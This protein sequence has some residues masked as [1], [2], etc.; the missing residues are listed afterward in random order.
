VAGRGGGTRGGSAGKSGDGGEAGPGSGE[1]LKEYR[2]KRDFGKTREPA[3]AE[4]EASR[5]GRLRFIIQKHRASHLHYDLRLEMGGVL[6]S[7][8]VPKGPSR[9]PTVRRL[10]MAVEDHPIEYGDFEGTIPAGEYGGGT[11][12]LWDRGTYRRGVE[13]GEEERALLGDLER[14]KLSLIF[15]GERLRGGYTLVRSGSRDGGDRQWLLIKQR[16]AEAEE[17]SELTEEV[18]TSVATGRRMEEIAV[19]AGGA[20][21]WRSNRKG[22][23]RG[24]AVRRAAVPDVASF[25]PMLA[26][27]GGGMPSGDEWTFELKYDGIRVLAVARGRSVGLI[28]RNGNDK[29][30]QFPE[31]VEALRALVAAVGRPLILDGE[32]VALRQGGVARF[33]ALQGRM[34]LTRRA[35]IEAQREAAPAAFVAFDLLLEGRTVH[36]PLAWV[37]RREALEGVFEGLPAEAAGTVRLAE[38]SRDGSGMRRQ[39]EREGW[40]GLVAKRVEAPYALGKR[41]PAWRKIK[42]ENRQEL[43]VGGYT[44]PRKS[45]KHIGSLLLGYYD[46]AG[47]LIYAGHTGT[48]FNRE[49]LE[50]LGRRLRRLER[51]TPPFRERPRTNET[52]HWVTPKLVVEVKFN[53]WTADGKLRQPSF[54][55]LRDDKDPRAV[56]REPV[57]G[58][59]AVE[60]AAAAPSSPVAAALAEI[61]AGGGDGVVRPGRGAR[62]SVTNLGKVFFPGPGYTK[63]D[64]LRYYADMAELILPA[65]KDRPLVLKR[66]PN[67]IGGQSFYQQTPAEDVPKGVRVETVSGEEGE[68]QRRLVGGELAT[69]LYTVQLGAISYDPWHSRVGR[70]NYPDYAIVDLDPGPD[71][72]FQRVVEVARRVREAMDELGLSG[73]LKTSGAS[74]LHISLPLPARTPAEAA[75]LVAQIVA[76]RVAQRHPAIA[77]VERMTRNR[78]AGTVYVDY[79]QNI[80]G[81]TIAGVYAVRAREGA[82][83][84]TPLRWEELKDGLDPM[85]FTIRTVPE[86][87]ARTGDLWAAGM[88]RKNTLKE[89]LASKR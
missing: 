62:L 40:E 61:E 59:A 10:A 22:G 65:M 51:K 86:R 16:D 69:L 1:R 80:V 13:E 9:D 67:G 34:H 83:V 72:P 30:R 84:S 37:A 20:R 50:S 21:V 45:R 2:R 47:D 29:A 54:V 4:R 70:L 26:S 57:L 79:L 41:S 17:G 6:K 56:V 15:E 89:L 5:E 53:E 66:Y 31:I 77:T 8:A 7:W 81:K 60:V 32:I 48:G 14:G 71:V 35:E 78:P 88:K 87:V 49:T 42:L 82:T 64:V 38:T 25:R 68:V 58:E 46:A 12:M 3:G 44:E 24:Q 55:G 76:T 85:A 18:D 63:G 27:A 43:V 52:A 11:V 33:G 23:G 74:G 39:A 19:G 28:T 36:V 73:A 75:T